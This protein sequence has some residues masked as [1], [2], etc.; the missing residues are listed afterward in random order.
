MRKH[1]LIFDWSKSEASRRDKLYSVTIVGLLFALAMGM[2]ELKLPSHRTDAEAQGTLIRLA[3]KEMAKSWALVAEENG[4]FPGRL[5]TEGDYEGLLFDKGQGLA[6]WTDYEPRLRPLREDPGVARVDITPKGKREFPMVA[7][8]DAART[9]AD[10]GTVS[11]P[12]APVL[13]PYHAAALDWLPETLPDFGLPG[14]AE[15]T[16]D[17]LRFLVSLREDGSVAEL[18]PLAGAAD[19]AQA[20]VE[21]WLRGIRFRDGDGERWFGLRVDFENRR[22]NEPE[23]E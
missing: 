12:G 6:W 3:D 17:A 2:I 4:P 18:I 11:S 10:P 5:E 13:I 15:R 21:G 14:T 1:P 23:P 8:G 9:A 16:T 19:P 7:T 22:E 20:A